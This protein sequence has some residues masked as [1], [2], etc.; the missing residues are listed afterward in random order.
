M[1]E[2]GAV[3]LAWIPSVWLA[4]GRPTLEEGGCMSP[5]L[6]HQDLS[7]GSQSLKR[8]HSFHS[9]A[10]VEEGAQLSRHGSPG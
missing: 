8:G 1:E 4:Q 3:S 2:G 5:S 7:W 10:V 9:M 6:T